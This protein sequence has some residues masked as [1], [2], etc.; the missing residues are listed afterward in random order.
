MYSQIP[1]DFIIGGEMKG[2]AQAFLP[3]RMLGADGKP[4]IK[5]EDPNSEI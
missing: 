5:F 3:N 1:T 2:N 4:G